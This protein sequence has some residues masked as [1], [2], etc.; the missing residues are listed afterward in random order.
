MV[1]VKVCQCESHVNKKLS[2]KTKNKKPQEKIGQNYPLKE[3]P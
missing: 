1:F 2:K 3:T